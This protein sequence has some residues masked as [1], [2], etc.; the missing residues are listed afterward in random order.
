MVGIGKKIGRFEKISLILTL[1][2][3]NTRKIAASIPAPK[4]NHRKVLIEK[5]SELNTFLLRAVFLIT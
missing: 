3:T 2:S 1:E 5:S 4:V